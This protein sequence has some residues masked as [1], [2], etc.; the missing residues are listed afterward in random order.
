MFGRLKELREFKGITQEEIASYLNISRSTYAGYETGKD[1]IP[2]EKLNMVANYFHTSL[3]YIIGESPSRDKIL[4]VQSINKK[5]IS[6]T[7]K[8]IRKEKHLTQKELA[9][10]LKTSQSNIHKYE[11]EKA[12]ITTYYALEFSKQ[13]H[14]SLDK[15]VGRKKNN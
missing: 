9:N 1:M 8:K 3:D 5:N 12:L 11:K 2:L 14:Y 4:E 15:L 7:I 13:Y 10:S 6:K